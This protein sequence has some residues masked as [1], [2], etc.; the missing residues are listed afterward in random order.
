MT[1]SGAPTTYRD[2]HTALDLLGISGRATLA[3]IKD[4]HRVLVKRHHP[5]TGNPSDPER[6]RLINEA[7]RTVMEYLSGYRFSFDEDEFY[8]QNPEERLRMQFSHDPLWGDR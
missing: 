5:D 4:R 3:E 1:P 6:I 7:Y 8:E 2:L